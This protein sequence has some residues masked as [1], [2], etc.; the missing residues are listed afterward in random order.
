MPKMPSVTFRLDSEALQ[1]LDKLCD[2]RRVSRSV[3][4]AE[5]VKAYLKPEES[6]AFEVVAKT[7]D[8]LARTQANTRKLIEGELM[9]M[10]E[11]L[12]LYVLQWLIHTPPL[13]EQGRDQAA[14]EGHARFDRFLDR[15]ARVSAGGSDRLS[16]EPEPRAFAADEFFEEEAND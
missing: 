15:V 1:A 10:R 11:M 7:L 2:K 13:P 12:G 6:D 8:N 14:R 16:L 3:V 9:T 4:I 5:A